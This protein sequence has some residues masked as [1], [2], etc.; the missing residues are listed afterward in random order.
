[1]Q[2]LSTE[3]EIVENGE[4]IGSEDSED[5]DL[6]DSYD[7]SDSF[8]VK[9]SEIVSDDDDE[10]ELAEEIAPTKRRRSRMV[11]ES[12]SDD[13]NVTADDSNNTNE[14]VSIS[15]QVESVVVLE[16]SN[17]S[18]QEIVEGKTFATTCL[19][20]ENDEREAKAG[21]HV[22]KNIEKAVV[23]TK[24]IENESDES[25]SLIES[26][27]SGESNV[28]ADQA[29]SGAT[30]KMSD[31]EVV[32]QSVPV[33]ENIEQSTSTNEKEENVSVSQES[34]S[35][36]VAMESN[37]A[38]NGKILAKKQRT[39]LP[40]IDRLQKSSS[41]IGKKAN[42]MSLGDLNP[43]LRGELIDSK[44]LAKSKSVS[45]KIQLTEAE[46]IDSTI[47]PEQ[48]QATTDDSDIVNT[49]SSSIENH[50]PNHSKAALL[51]VSSQEEENNNRKNSPKKCMYFRAFPYCFY[52]DCNTIRLTNN[53]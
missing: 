34:D 9:D 42:R 19:V 10:E 18:D 25:E 33:P 36:A 3:N 17:A 41:K 6:N 44:S 24:A 43:N 32:T 22:E 15:L 14:I 30:T 28:M 5:E 40:G 37:E 2:I 46:D 50:S 8:L 21:A 12:S 52:C 26:N 47:A 31:D 53:G 27:A 45:S 35:G 1:M 16:G 13:S 11:V 20:S 29:D 39:S 38:H 51:N 49:S 4:D 48:A 23:E 7:S